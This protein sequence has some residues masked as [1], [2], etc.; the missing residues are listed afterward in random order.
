VAVVEVMKETQ[1]ELVLLVDLVVLAVVLVDLLIQIM[2][3][4]VQI[5]LMEL[6]SKEIL[7]VQIQG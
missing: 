4:V 6:P 2:V 7:V 5:H 1:M 3:V